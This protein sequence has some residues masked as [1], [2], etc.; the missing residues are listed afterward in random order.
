MATVIPFDPGLF[1]LASLVGFVVLTL[2][3][4]WTGILCIVRPAASA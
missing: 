3:L 1:G 2:W 4:I